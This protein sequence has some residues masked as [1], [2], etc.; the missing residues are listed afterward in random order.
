[1]RVVTRGT[2][3]HGS[4]RSARRTTASRRDRPARVRC[5]AAA[6]SLVRRCRGPVPGRP[7]H[8]VRGRPRL[9]RRH[10]QRWRRPDPPR[11]GS[12]ACRRQAP[13]PLAE[14]GASAGIVRAAA[15]VDPSLSS[16]PLA[17]PGRVPDHGRVV[18]GDTQL[19]G[20]VVSSPSACHPTAG[21]LAV[22]S[23]EHDGRIGHRRA[24]LDDERLDPASRPGEVAEVVASARSALRSVPAAGG[25]NEDKRMPPP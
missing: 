20:E 11:A 9:P 1:M 23:D 25:N 22:V 4:V 12:S 6:G 16:G 21:P 2:A 15:V 24:R 14:A 8:R 13:L 3:P 19:A 5:R 17:H 18:R 10:P 7:P